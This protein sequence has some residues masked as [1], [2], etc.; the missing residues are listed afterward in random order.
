M[1]KT[2][3]AKNFNICL[4][5]VATGGSHGRGKGIFKNVTCK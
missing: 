4:S 1:T 3:F 2:N 5:I